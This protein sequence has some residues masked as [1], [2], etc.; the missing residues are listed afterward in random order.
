MMWAALGLLGGLALGFALGWIRRG[1]AVERQ[2]ILDAGLR[3]GR[4]RSQFQ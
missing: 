1:Q 3:I 4:T 2:Q